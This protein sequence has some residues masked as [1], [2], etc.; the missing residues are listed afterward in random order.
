MQ[1]PITLTELN[2]GCWLDNHRGH[3]IARD[4]ILLAVEHGF[5]IGGMERFALD[6]YDDH[7]GDDGYPFEELTD[8]CDAA[9]QWLN[10]GQG[11]CEHCNGGTGFDG[12][13]CRV[14]SGTGRGPREGGQNFPPIVPNGAV[15]TFY[16]GDF[17]L[18]RLDDDGEPVDNDVKYTAE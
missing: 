9:V 13:F 12:D 17:G 8:L 7:G 15:W 5:I 10:S 4:T 6:M 14:C 3:Y 2:I 1:K 18:Y 11:K 16:D